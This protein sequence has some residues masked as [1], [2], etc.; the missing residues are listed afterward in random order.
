MKKGIHPD[1]HQVVFKDTSTG[2]AFK[3]GSTCKS[4]KTIT[5]KDGKKYPLIL[6]EISSD[7]HPFYTGK[8]NL[9]QTA[10]AV[11]KFN[12]RYGLDKKSRK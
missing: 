10:G 4:K 9:T 7:S 8:E 5:W 1:Y 3:T 12:K 11:D 2:F 6:V